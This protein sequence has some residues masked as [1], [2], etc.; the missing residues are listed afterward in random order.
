MYEWQETQKPD[1]KLVAKLCGTKVLVYA[2]NVDAPAA[3]SWEVR[4]A[5]GQVQVG[6]ADDPDGALEKG[7]EVA[8]RFLP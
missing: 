4:F 1:G 2:S 6:H 5:D 3:W 8:E 7:K